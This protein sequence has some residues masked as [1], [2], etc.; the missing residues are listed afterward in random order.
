MAVRQSIYGDKSSWIPIRQG[1]SVKLANFGDNTATIAKGFSEG[2]LQ[3][4]K[5]FNTSIVHSALGIESALSRM[6]VIKNKEVFAEDN[7]EQT[8]WS[9]AC[10]GGEL[11][12]VDA[13]YTDNTYYMLTPKTNQDV[14]TSGAELIT[15]FSYKTLR[16]SII[17]SAQDI[18]TSTSTTVR[19]DLKTYCE[20]FSGTHP[21]IT[22]VALA[23][24]EKSGDSFTPLYVRGLKGFIMHNSSVYTT[25]LR[26]AS[27]T[28]GKGKIGA[29]LG[30]QYGTQADIATFNILG[31][32]NQRLA[33]YRIYKTDINIISGD[34]KIH[35]D[36]D[37]AYIYIEYFEGFMEYAMHQAACFGIQFVT[38]TT[39]IDVDLESDETTE[40]E[41]ENVYIGVLDADFIGHGDFI[42]GKAI[43][44]NKQ[45]GLES[46]DESEYAPLEPE[47]DDIGD[48]ES[49]THNI[50]GGSG[51]LTIYNMNEANIVRLMQ[52]LNSEESGETGQNYAQYISSVKYSAFGYHLRGSEETV[53]VGGQLVSV[54]GV[55]VK[56][57]KGYRMD[58]VTTDAYP[59]ERYWN[60]FRDFEP[61]TTIA[62]K[63]PFA[64]TIQLNC[65]EWYGHNLTV[66]YAVDEVS[67]TGIAIIYR[68]A[69]QWMS[70]NVSMFTDVPLTS[71]NAGTYHNALIQAK[72]TR[73]SALIGIGASALSVGA[74]AAS[75]NVVGAAASG[76]GLL[77][78]IERYRQSD[79]ALNHMTK[80]ISRIGSSGDISDFYF[81]WRPNIIFERRRAL[82]Y[83]KTV[84]KNTVGYAC[85]KTGKL[86][87]FSGLTVCSDVK[88]SDFGATAEEK[89]MIKEALSKGVYL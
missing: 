35:T 39:Y 63:I 19:T 73:N 5:G 82:T 28:F 83:D 60:D 84:Y 34:C 66:R 18:I 65:G 50:S 77:T 85:L 52:W 29:L 24:Y 36:S 14:I 11:H 74:S 87:Q 45:Y 33:E 88:L 69:L 21:I 37:R 86:S 70:V 17:V 10:G 67:G 80:S 75:G 49:M 6:Q 15:D 76:A 30:A 53:K 51:G 68:D 1:S 61:Y 81:E 4:D 64:D 8:M 42:N 25:A 12:D 55:A 57:I 22:S 59:I 27:K 78:S 62:L 26:S 43:L 2:K 23:L 58:S 32:L 89:R 38:D 46:A 72:T 20:Q 48:L 44:Q 71:I 56:G 40:A 7:N 79:Y 16:A 9:F 3:K 13:T 47:D 41:A 54:G 31:L